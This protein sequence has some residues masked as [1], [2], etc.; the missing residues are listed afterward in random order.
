MD[1]YRR[2]LGIRYWTF[3]RFGE[4]GGEGESDARVW[5]DLERLPFA[6]MTYKSVRFAP[7]ICAPNIR[8]SRL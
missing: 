1:G 7:S 6:D 5:Q 8:A 2:F 4:I 3:R